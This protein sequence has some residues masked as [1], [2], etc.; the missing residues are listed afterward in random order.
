MCSV[1][2]S[3]SVLQGVMWNTDGSGIVRQI[4]HWPH[5]MWITREQVLSSWEMFNFIWLTERERVT[6]STTPNNLGNRQSSLSTSALPQET[7]VKK[8]RIQANHP[9]SSLPFPLPRRLLREVFTVTS[10]ISPAHRSPWTSYSVYLTHNKHSP[11]SSSVHAS[12]SDFLCIPKCYRCQ[13]SKYLSLDLTNWSSTHACDFRSYKTY[14]VHTKLLI[15]HSPNSVSYLSIKQH[16]TSENPHVPAQSA[17][18]HYTSLELIT[19][20]ILSLLTCV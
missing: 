4:P 7:E 3:P 1:A 14:L 5:W 12:T 18:H 20:L 15:V 11:T 10:H 19:L 16:L 2:G 6:L 8:E 9:A 17:P 13:P